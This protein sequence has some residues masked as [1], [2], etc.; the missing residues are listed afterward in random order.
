MNIIH[1]NLYHAIL[2][3][4]AVGKNFEKRAKKIEQQMGLS[5]GYIAE[6]LYQTI[7]KSRYTFDELLK[8][9]EKMIK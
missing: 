4:F 2:F 7:K 5:A 3:D 9:M 1:V 8:A 6:I